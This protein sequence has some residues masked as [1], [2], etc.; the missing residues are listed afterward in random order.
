MSTLLPSCSEI[1]CNRHVGT[2]IFLFEALDDF[3]AA[4]IGASSANIACSVINTFEGKTT[5][6]RSIAS[7]ATRLTLAPGL[8]DERI[9]WFFA[10]LALLRKSDGVLDGNAFTALFAR[11]HAGGKLDMEATP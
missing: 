3:I 6:P 7:C 10:E 1:R 8:D 5:L 11:L 4:T 2:I 9:L